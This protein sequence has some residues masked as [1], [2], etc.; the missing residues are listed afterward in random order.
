MNWKVAQG[1]NLKFTSE[2]L[3]PDR[4]IGH[5]HKVRHSLVYELTPIPFVQLRTGL[6]KNGG[7]PQNDFDNR[8]SVFVELHAFM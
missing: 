8:R 2:L 3:D 4:A 6:R 1:H 5:D 7:I